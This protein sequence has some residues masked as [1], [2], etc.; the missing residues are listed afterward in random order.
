M[1]RRP[2]FGVTGGGG[3]FCNDIMDKPL[4]GGMTCPAGNLITL[5]ISR[6]FFRVAGTYFGQ[7][8]LKLVTLQ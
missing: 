4:A 2:P 8:T 7:L 3:I 5:V 6:K 1:V